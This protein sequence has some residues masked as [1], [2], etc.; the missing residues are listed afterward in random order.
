MVEALPL[1]GSATERN[2]I[3]IFVGTEKAALM[4]NSLQAQVQTS[5]RSSL[6]FRCCG[7]R[8]RQPMHLHLELWAV[9]GCP[10]P[11]P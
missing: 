1:T 4:M 5:F 7:G 2:L 11:A 3:I 9:D 6:C 8:W 10:G